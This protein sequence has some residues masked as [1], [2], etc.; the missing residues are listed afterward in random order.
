MK[1]NPKTYTH[2]QLNAT[3]MHITQSPA[4]TLQLLSAIGIRETYTWEQINSGLY[5]SGVSAARL[6]GVL[7]QLNSYS[8]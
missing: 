1:T 7:H 3:L 8:R 5:E 2:E 6:V 4:R